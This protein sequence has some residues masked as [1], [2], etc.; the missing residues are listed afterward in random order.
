[1]RAGEPVSAA[2]EAAASGTSIGP[3][4]KIADHE[5]ATEVGRD[6]GNP[7]IR[8]LALAWLNPQHLK[9]M[10]LFRI[11]LGRGSNIAVGLFQRGSPL[12]HVAFS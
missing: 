8:T 11:S 5:P 7:R 2:K 1:V 10:G 9:G 6:G 12:D 3:A 4:A